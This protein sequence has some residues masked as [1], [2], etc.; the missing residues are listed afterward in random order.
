M[1]NILLSLVLG[2]WVFSEAA[3]AQLTTYG[4]W[5]EAQGAF[6]QAQPAAG[7][8]ADYFAGPW[9]EGLLNT[10]Q[11]KRLVGP[12]ALYPDPLLAQVLPASTNP[13]DVVKAARLV[14]ANP[15]TAPDA[16]INLDASVQALIHYPEV[17]AILD[18]H[19]DW[20]ERLGRAFIDQPDDVITAVQRLREVARWYGNLTTTAEQEVVIDPDSIRILPATEY[21]YVPVYEPTVVYTHACPRTY[22]YVTFRSCSWIGPWYDLD[23][24]WRRRVLCRRDGWSWRDYCGRRRTWS[25]ANVAVTYFHNDCDRPVHDWHSNRR[26]RNDRDGRWNGRHDGDDRH[27]HDGPDRDD[28]PDH[29]NRPPRAA[30][31]NPPH[32]TAPPPPPPPPPAPRE[33]QAPHRTPRAAERVDR[34][35]ASRDRS[36]IPTPRAEDS[37]TGPIARQPRRV[38]PSSPRAPE[39]PGMR[40]TETPGAVAS[41]KPN[42]SPALDTPKAAPKSPP[43][44]ERPAPARTAPPP[45]P[46]APPPAPK[47]AESPKPAPRTAPRAEAPIVRPA[48][49]PPAPKPTTPAAKAEAPAPK[50]VARPAADKDDSP[51]AKPERRHRAKSKD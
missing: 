33:P 3:C 28:R 7:P 34:P 40:A 26:D 44:V 8:P 30:E 4:P 43:K 31:P 2:A 32:I 9:P 14:R 48:P 11:V 6:D 5:P 27:G 49:K 15:E 35:D 25:D 21:V 38:R 41:A 46:P 18:E 42:P 1:T 45:P 50:P 29:G 23:C 37:R 16:A 10:E 22:R 19:L 51:A 12:I 36:V 20:T 17:L 13:L 24:D 47:A 39:T